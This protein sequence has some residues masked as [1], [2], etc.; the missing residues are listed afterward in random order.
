MTRA[1]GALTGR[2]PGAWRGSIGFK[3]AGA[4]GA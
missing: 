1:V 4:A 3:T 2:P